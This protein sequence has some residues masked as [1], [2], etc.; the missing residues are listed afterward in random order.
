[1]QSLGFPVTQVE[2]V[3]Y[4]VSLKARKGWLLRYR[5]LETK[6][7]IPLYVKYQTTVFTLQ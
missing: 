4:N 5:A 3:D 2:P 7:L 1:M 6:A